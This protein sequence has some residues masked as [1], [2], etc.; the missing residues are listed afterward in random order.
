MWSTTTGDSSIYL[1]TYRPQS[2]PLDC[3][4]NLEF[5]PSW[6]WINLKFGP[7]ILC[8]SSPSTW[9]SALSYRKSWQFNWSQNKCLSFIRAWTCTTEQNVSKFTTLTTARQLCVIL[10]LRRLET[11]ESHIWAEL[12]WML[13]TS[14]NQCDEPS[15]IG[16]KICNFFSNYLKKKSKTFSSPHK[17]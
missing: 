7:Y 14:T 9:S 12:E 5:W 17:I 13:I 4:G 15:C 16:T 10:C 11:C 3:C 1:M 6:N 8:P 2:L